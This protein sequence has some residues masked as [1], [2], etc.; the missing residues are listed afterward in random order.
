VSLELEGTIGTR[1]IEIIGAT[2]SE[3]IDIPR[4]HPG[5]GSPACAN[6]QAIHDHEPPGPSVLRVTGTCLFPQ[7]GYKVELSR[8]APQGINPADL[9][10]DLSIDEPEIGAH[11][12]TEVEARY[13]ETTEFDYQTVTI[14]P[15]PT[16]PVQDVH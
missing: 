8:A 11:V 7:S 3:R 2:R 13:E 6:W 16:I 9:I 12:I 15:G 4:A 14:R 5:P 1:G 10:L